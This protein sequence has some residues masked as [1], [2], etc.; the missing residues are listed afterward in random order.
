MAEYVK[1]GDPA[2]VLF[3]LGCRRIA[4]LVLIITFFEK[5]KIALW[6]NTEIAADLSTGASYVSLSALP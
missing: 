1:W 5:K 6:D 4:W 3:N 2:D